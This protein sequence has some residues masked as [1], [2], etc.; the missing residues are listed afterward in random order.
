MA[1]AALC[2][3]STTAASAVSPSAI[4]PDL[5]R[6]VNKWSAL[7]L[8]RLTVHA[9]IVEHVG[10]RTRRGMAVLAVDT[11]PLRETSTVTI[12]GRTYSY[13]GLDGV[14]YVL[15]PDV[16]P[17][18]GPRHWLRATGAELSTASNP[19]QRF[20]RTIVHFVRTNL[21]HARA[22]REVGPIAVGGRPTTEF[23]VTLPPPL[24]TVDLYF[25]YDGRLVRG[26]LSSP[27]EVAAVDLSATAPVR[28]HRPPAG[29]TVRFSD[30]PR[31]ER[32]KANNAATADIIAAGS[33]ALI[34]A[35][36]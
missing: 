11:A 33:A 18:V 13:R 35:G 1:L 10:G 19:V 21:I 15:G 17:I 36:L 32:T 16:A 4:P 8:S 30:L 27:T 23:T 5:T 29:L 12:G 26:V 34:L 9:T 31:A 28:V 2:A 7:P 3:V 14:N 22:V 20:Q 6:L 25:A 24:G